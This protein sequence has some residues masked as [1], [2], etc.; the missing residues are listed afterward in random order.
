MSAN[1]IFKRE[2]RVSW[3]PGVTVVGRV[4]D[5]EEWT[6][7]TLKFISASPDMQELPETVQAKLAIEM[8]N[9]G[10]RFVIRVEGMDYKENT[11]FDESTFKY[12]PPVI[13][14]KLGTALF[15]EASPDAEK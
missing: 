12:I 15:S 7:L 5:T 3:Q 11:P 10:L 6:E 1:L 14:M 9:I 13:L 2:I 8:A 4:A